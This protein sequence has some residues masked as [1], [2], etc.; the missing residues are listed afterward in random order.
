MIANR[1]IPA[2]LIYTLSVIF[3]SDLFAIIPDTISIDNT[4]LTYYT[5]KNS[6]ADTLN[7]I[8][9]MHGGV[10]QFKNKTSVIDISTS[11]LVEGNKDFLNTFQE[12]GY[13]IILPIAYNEYNWLEPNGEIFI[14]ELI[15]NLPNKYNKII[16]SGFSDG[17]TG[18]YRMFYNSPEIYD[19]VV[20]FNGY[21]QLKNYYKK[22]SHI[23]S[24]KTIIYC[25]TNSDKVIPYEFLLI[26]YRRQKMINEHT[27]F[28]LADGGHNFQD[29]TKNSFNNI[30]Q[31]IENQNID[32]KDSMLI[33]P[34][35]DGL[36]INNIVE[37]TYPFRKKI[38]RSYSMSSTEY[39]DPI[40][41]Y[42]EFSKL[43]DQG[44]RIII[45][46]TRIDSLELKTKSYI[47][48]PATI[49]GKETTVKYT[50]WLVH[51]TW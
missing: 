28:T 25:S 51:P 44:K 49:D 5:I 2:M 45:Q 46:P 21:P 31:L 3:P 41:H 47:E 11:E 17:G 14:K 37:N 26:E 30:L 9:Y 13:D 42:K 19:G 22:V 1:F 20:I 12:A 33:Y 32:N 24:D 6:K 7:L 10:S 15:S 36:H 29:Y 34:P 18:A 27:Y 35:V 50:N 40:E 48:F 38:G 23:R 16:I 8:I 39:D 43:I 4:K